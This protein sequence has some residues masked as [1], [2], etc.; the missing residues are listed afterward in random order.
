MPA[1]P[2]SGLAPWF[3]L[4]MLPVMFV[5]FSF[6][7]SWM[8]GWSRLAR[9]YRLDRGGGFPCRYF[10]S[11]GLGLV[12]YR[13]CLIVGGDARGLYLAVLL[14]FRVGHPPLCI[15]WADLQDRV[16]ER[17]F[18]RYC[19]TF[20]VGPDRLKLRIQSSAMKSLDSY[21]PAARQA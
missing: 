20:R 11:G 12:N 15:P 2:A 18:F 7:L 6:T 9:D 3:P 16:R 14:P 19:D 4:V 21:L 5:L 10:V 1:H 13:N 8:G 17:W